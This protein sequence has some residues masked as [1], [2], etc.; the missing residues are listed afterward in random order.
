MKTIRI[1]P[2]QE[3]YNRNVNITRRIYGR[4]VRETAVRLTLAELWHRRIINQEAKMI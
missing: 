3:V 2:A 4:V 1:I